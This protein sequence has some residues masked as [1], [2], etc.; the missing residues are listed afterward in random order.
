MIKD[1]PEPGSLAWHCKHG[2]LTPELLDQF[3]DQLTTV[4]KERCNALHFAAAAG[5]AHVVA[6]L[7]P[8][9]LPKLQAVLE[10]KLKAKLKL[11]AKVKDAFVDKKAV[12]NA[13]DVKTA[14]GYTALLLACRGAHL[15]TMR[16]LLEHKAD[17]EA[18]DNDGYT[19][20]SSFLLA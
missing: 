1:K 18:C 9:L 12:T 16:V 14:G 2:T 19:A 10:A 15:N 13:V 8:K 4:S 20:V 5:H 3:D 17:V 6:M 11:Q 7:L